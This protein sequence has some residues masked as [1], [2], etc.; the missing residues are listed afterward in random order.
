MNGITA[1]SGSG[2]SCG[3]HPSDPARIL[4][5]G[6][7]TKTSRVI[8]RQPHGVA[9]SAAWTNGLARTFS[10]GCGSWGGNSVSENVTQ[11]HYYNSTRIAEPINQPVP[12]EAAI[13]GRLYD[14]ITATVL[15]AEG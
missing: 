11:K 2:H 6:L 7:R 9:N 15:Q 8:V 4:E 3:I 13:Y 12:T 10:L 1:F 14:K 5:L